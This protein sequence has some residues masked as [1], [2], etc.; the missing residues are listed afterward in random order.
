MEQVQEQPQRKGMSKGCLV[1]LI[2]GG[3]LLV[4]IVILFAFICAKREQIVQYG[5]KMVMQNIKVEMVKAHPVGLD[6]SQFDAL[7]D[8]FMVRFSQSPL[9]STKSMQ[10]T[11]DLQTIMADKK[12]DA[13]DVD[14][15]ITMITNYYPDLEKYRPTYSPEGTAGETTKP[16]DSTS[17][18]K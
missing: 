7:I 5:T 17:P 1:G 18:A 14:P 8:S 6:T 11:K 10:M 9:D 13:N 4:L 12:I 3:A 16:P 15:I 2:V